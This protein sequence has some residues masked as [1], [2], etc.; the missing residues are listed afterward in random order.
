MQDP[1]LWREEV[2]SSS[3]GSGVVVWAPQFWSSRAQGTS[4]VH[5]LQLLTLLGAW[6][7]SR[8]HSW[9]ALCPPRAGQRSHAVAAFCGSPGH[10]FEHIRIY[11]WGHWAGPGR[12]HWPAVLFCLGP[13]PSDKQ[14]AP[15]TMTPTPPAGRVSLQTRQSD[16]VWSLALWAGLTPGHGG[17]DAKSLGPC[18]P[19]APCRE[20][21]EPAVRPQVVFLAIEVWGQ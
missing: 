9:A 19:R 14:Q 7:R 3:P 13:K 12:S 16:V 21:A 11:L 18:E 4:S 20:G 5:R 10:S 6:A 8:W 15:V 17:K 2:S 1:W